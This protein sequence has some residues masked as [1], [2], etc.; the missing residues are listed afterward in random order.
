MQKPLALLLTLILFASSI[1]CFL[2]TN[3]QSNTITVPT[4]YPTLSAAIGNA[5]GGDTII[6]KNGV[7]TE[8]T[9]DVN[10]TLHIISQNIGGASLILHPPNYTYPYFTINLIAWF[11]PIKI[12]ADNVE[13]SGFSI[14]S[15]GGS[16]TVTGASAQISNNQIYNSPLVVSANNTIITGNKLPIVMLNGFNQTL[17]DNSLAHLFVNGAYNTISRN[18]GLDLTLNG[19]YNLIN[20]NVFKFNSSTDG[21]SA[22][23]ILIQTGDHNTLSNNTVTGQGTGMAVGY[24][25][26]G[27]SY[28]LFVGNTVKN[29]DL[30][31]I[32]MANGSYNVFY[33]NL[34]ANNTGYGH[35]GYGIALGGNHQQVNSNLF[36]G[37][38]LINNTKNFNV[39]WAINEV[40]YFDNGKEGN[41][42]DDYLTKY[43]NAQ[44][45]TNIGTGNQKYL[46]YTNINGNYYDNYPLMNKPDLSNVVSSLP[47]PWATLLQITLAD[48]PQ[49][50]VTKTPSST[51]SSDSSKK[52]LTPTTA[53]LQKPTLS[54]DTDVIIN[55]TTPPVISPLEE[56]FPFVLVAMGIAIVGIAAISVGILLERK[57]AKR[58][59]KQHLVCCS[60]SI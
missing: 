56:Q 20:D 35:D 53:P 23:G 2:P 48:E 43:P 26:Q 42:W 21:Y 59:L 19:S 50:I 25:G 13:L 3:A 7:Y 6:V 14:T 22:S 55:Y 46:V 27:G 41:Y 29:A 5:T 37:N 57:S 28:N 8:Q 39:N 31:G 30:W 36:Y 38:I 1:I 4:D 44:E 33:G 11:D 45:I 34:I 51:S 15:D 24:T 12:T 60:K 9:L 32:L 58:Y 18:N 10:K 49:P 16:I 17:I 52:S 47:E 40:N 54:P